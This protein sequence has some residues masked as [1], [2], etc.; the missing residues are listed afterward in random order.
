MARRFVLF[1]ILLAMLFSSFAF[2]DRGLDMRSL[3][4]TGFKTAYHNILVA[5]I[6]GSPNSGAGM[7]FDLTRPDVAY[8]QLTETNVTNVHTSGR[9][10]ATWSVHSNYTPITIKIDAEPLKHTTIETSDSGKKT[11]VNY[12]LYFPYRYNAVNA[13]ADSKESVTGFMRV[14]SGKQYQSDKDTTWKTLYGT[15]T[16]PISNEIVDVTTGVAGLGISTGDYPVRFMLAEDVV[17]ENCEPGTYNATVTIVVE[18]D[19]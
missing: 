13:T 1:V 11:E 18:G 16:N 12:I 8:V 9:A 10:I 14:E 15:E 6:A 5:P 4:L 17:I 3:S 19:Q 2:A 7:P